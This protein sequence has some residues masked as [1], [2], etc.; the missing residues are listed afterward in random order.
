MPQL[1]LQLLGPFQATLDERPLTGF[2]SNKVRALLAYLAVEADRPHSRDELIGLLWPDQ[3]DATARANLRQALANLRSAIG[4]RTSDKPFLSTTSDSIQF[5]RTELCTIDVVVFTELLAACKAHVH[6][7]LETCR[8]CAQR[9]QQAVELYRGDFLAQFVQS[10]SE[11]FE[12]WALIQRERLHREVLDA[13]YVLAEHHD[14]RSEYDRMRQYAA[15]QLELDPWREEAHRQLMR[16][17]ALSGQRSAALAQYEVC[18]RVLA[19][20][21][22]AE[23]SQETVTLQARIKADRLT[24]ADQQHNLPTTL[25]SLI[26][27]GRELAEI[28][29][30][31]ETP[32]CRLLTLTGPGGIGKTRLALQAASDHIGLFADGVWLVELAAL[33]DPAFVPQAIASVLDLREQ[34]TRPLQD[35][36]LDF[37]KQREL[38]LVLDNC[39]HL[40]EACARI[41]DDL[42]RACPQLNILATSRE[43]LNVAGEVTFRVPPLTMPDPQQVPA[44]APLIQYEA[45]RLFVERA[46]VALPIFTLTDDNGQVVTQICHRLDGM[47]LAIELAAARV[48]VLSVD[49]IAIRLNDRFSLLT[50]GHRTTIPRHQT[51]RATLDWSYDLLSPV[52]KLMLNRLSVFAGGWTLE[53]AEALAGVDGIEAREVLNGLSRLVDKSLV[54]ISREQ[55]EKRFGMLETIRQYTWDRLLESDEID[56]AR[57]RHLEF[58]L[59]LAEEKSFL[60]TEFILMNQLAM[61]YPNLREALEWSLSSGQVEAGLRLANVLFDFWHIRGQVSEGLT[62][63]KRALAVDG[64]ASASSRGMALFDLGGL[65][66]FQGNFAAARSYYEESLKLWQELGNKGEIAIALRKI[67][68]VDASEGT[69]AE[70]HVH[71]EQSLAI[72]REL[73][74]KY[75]IMRVLTSLGEISRTQ[76]DYARA[77]IFYRESLALADE[78][79][80]SWNRD[81]LLDNL[82]HVALHKGEYVQAQIHF[83]KVLVLSHR[84]KAGMDCTNYLA[85][86]AGVA[87]A[88]GDPGRAVTLF[89]AVK[90]QVEFLGT[91]L[92]YADHVEYER[93]LAAVRIQMEDDEFE[94]AWAK[95]FAM[96]FEQAI[97]Y[98]LSSDKD[99]D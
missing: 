37:L 15:R 28:D 14:R 82:A 47:P 48:N 88:S 51:L 89:A 97:E 73:E 49:Q 54:V 98:A 32:A 42:L 66:W 72:H 63:L 1:A 21:L 39:E 70:A 93:N 31:L 4:D 65:E 10:G 36:F 76:D 74:D 68:D 20:E 90:R 44:N 3:P 46:T 56:K 84:A 80:H 94:N 79:D 12:E 77:E 92:D 24:R 16:A 50:D 61:E 67:G 30:L 38:L 33:S 85:G 53:A 5:N 69:Y 99:A 23:P 95:G 17:L 52:E 2:E 62:W 8:S 18:R 81:L 41:T 7:R 91:R 59:T 83:Q 86:L 25:T 75:G 29:R 26:G 27:R 78:L 22:S 71:F 6:R 9:L 87:M 11:A 57:T 13:L 19:D 43:A 60:R 96:T 34:P 55:D 64:A 45:V 58:F 40:V 35:V